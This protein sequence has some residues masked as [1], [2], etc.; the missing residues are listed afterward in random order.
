MPPLAWTTFIDE[1]AHIITDLGSLSDTI[2]RKTGTN[3]LRILAEA[4][5]LDSAKTGCFLPAYLEP[6]GM[7]ENRKFRNSGTGSNYLILE[8]LVIFV[9]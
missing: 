7:S 6:V 4:G 3:L 2:I 8:G 5:Y 9:Q 1:R